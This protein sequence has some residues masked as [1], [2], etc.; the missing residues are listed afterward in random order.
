M[1]SA[2]AARKG[3]RH[4]EDAALESVEL[5]AAQTGGAGVE[6]HEADLGVE[7]GDLVG[8]E[9]AVGEVQPAAAFGREI[10]VTI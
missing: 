9:V 3:L 7:F 6:Q 1:N 4:A 5:S 2:F 10:S 8:G